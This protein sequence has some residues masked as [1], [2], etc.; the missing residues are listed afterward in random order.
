MVGVIIDLE[1][2]FEFN[3]IVHDIVEMIN[4]DWMC[5]EIMA[6]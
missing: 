6:V 1:L 2:M 5:T 3:P 4:I